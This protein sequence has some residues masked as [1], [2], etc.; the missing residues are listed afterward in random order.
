MC[1]QLDN[2]AARVIAKKLPRLTVLGVEYNNIGVFGLE[3]ILDGLADL[4]Y[5]YVGNGSATQEET[6][7]ATKA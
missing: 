5:L 4:K 1:C 7:S 6:P 2:S 3:S